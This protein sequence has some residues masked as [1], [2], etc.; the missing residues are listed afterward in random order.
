[1]NISRDVE[2]A[3]PYNQTERVR[4]S[5]G[6]GVPDRPRSIREH[7]VYRNYRGGS[8]LPT[9]SNRKTIATGN[10]RPRRPINANE[11]NKISQMITKNI[12][13]ILGAIKG[14]ALAIPCL[15]IWQASDSPASLRD[16]SLVKPSACGRGRIL[17]P[18]I[19][20]LYCIFIISHLF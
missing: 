11:H 15:G 4:K 1:M 13:P 2:D 17:P 6:A 18:Q 12:T 7:Y 16:N 10:L 3:V 19:P 5:V 9:R 8:R 14:I 20:Y